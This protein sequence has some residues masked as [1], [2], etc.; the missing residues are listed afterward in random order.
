MKV[1]FK[2]DEYDAELST[3]SSG[4]YVLHLPKVTVNTL[5]IADFLDKCPE[6]D[7]RMIDRTFKSYDVIY[8]RT[9]SRYSGEVVEEVLNAVSD[10]YDKPITVCLLSHPSNTN[11]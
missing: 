4:S 9:N 7:V 1:K 2:F 8:F 6:F 10:V 3:L 11:G 5:S